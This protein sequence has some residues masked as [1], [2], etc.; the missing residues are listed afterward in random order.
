MDYNHERPDIEALFPG[1]QNT[2]GPNGAVGFR[3][4]DTTTL[5]NGLH[6]ISWTVTDSQ[7]V[8]RRGSGAGSSRCRTGSGTA[9]GGGGRERSVESRAV[10]PPR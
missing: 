3:V 1:F 9:D 7:G 8:D 6:T 5:T 10:R 2:A 4:I